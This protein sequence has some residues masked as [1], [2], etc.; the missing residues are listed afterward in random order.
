VPEHQVGRV[1]GAVLSTFHVFAVGSVILAP[2]VAGSLGV[3]TTLGR[4][5]VIALLAVLPGVR[6]ATLTAAARSDGMVPG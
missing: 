2:W 6:C 5:G 4:E 3:P 1:I